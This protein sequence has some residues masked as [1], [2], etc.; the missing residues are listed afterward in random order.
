VRGQ[1]FLAA[2]CLVLAT[3]TGHAQTAPHRVTLPDVR[4]TGSRAEAASSVLGVRTVPLDEAPV[5]ATVI[6]ADV[7]QQPGVQ[8]ISAAIGRDPA[9]G[10]NYAT[11]GYYE[12]FS[13]RGFLLDLGSSYRVNGYVVPGEMHIALDN[14]ASIEILKGM[15]NL[16]GGTVGAGGTVNFVSR[17]PADVR[18]ARFELS[19]HGGWLTGVDLG[20]AQLGQ[21]NL[22]LRVNLAHEEMRPGAAGAQGRRDFMAI[23]ADAKH[24]PLN[25]NLD[26]EYG[27][28]AQPAVPGFQLLGGTALPADVDPLTNINSQPW[29]RPV[30]NES[31]LAALRARYALPGATLTTGISDG[32][33]RI[34]DSLAFPFGCNDPPYQYFCADGGYVLYDYRVF[35]RRRTRH[36][37][38][39]IETEL[40]LAGAKHEISFGIER[41]VRTVQQ[42]QLYSTTLYG[43]DGRALSG[44]LYA[45]GVALPAPPT[46]GVDMPSRRVEQPAVFMSDQVSW[47]AW[48]ANLGL[49][50]AR[51]D[52]KPVAL[53]QLALTRIASPS[54]RIYFNVARGLELGTEAPSVAQNAGQL[55]APRVVSQAE[56]G[57]RR[58][59][60]EGHSLSVALFRWRRPFEFT[61]PVGASWAG[62]G[63]FRQAGRQV[64]T[65]AEAGGTWRAHAALSLS[66][67]A[68]LLRAAAQGTG[69]AEFEGRQIQNVPR[70][71]WNGL[72]RYTV[73]GVSG[74]DVNLRWLYVGPRNARRDGLVSVPGYHRFDAGASWT[75]HAAGGRTTR[76]MLSV[77]NLANRRYW[78]DAGEAYSAD[79]LFPGRPRSAVFGVII[80][81]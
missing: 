14:R 77:E 18:S 62:L 55:L 2:A 31:R 56:L 6:G 67:Q 38:T 53:P 9:I 28:R 37:T 70:L 58:S 41:I 50:L 76:L 66:G 45:P 42:R 46:T 20:I 15:G 51:V 54:E 26:L 63:D 49:R 13:L 33:A 39:A 57:W 23:A 61:D 78:R 25:L 72:A 35:E 81:L 4:V 59:W 12:N 71:R 29:S 30:R 60:E 47:G 21:G 48:R 5:S 3:G 1:P 19:R 27:R 36:W 40:A 65:G 7:L 32:A 44:N 10:E 80:D 24:G 43:D 22:G 73:P 16:S 74:L 64:H 75:L 52:Q 34:D 69:V 8:S 68:A 11:T 17:R 79:L